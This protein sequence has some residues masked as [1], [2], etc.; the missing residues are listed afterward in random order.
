MSLATSCPFLGERA[1]AE[2]GRKRGTSEMHVLKR[3]A[4]L[5][6]S[7]HEKHFLTLRSGGVDTTF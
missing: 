7:A 6:E 2:T 1:K 4:V 3:G 5:E